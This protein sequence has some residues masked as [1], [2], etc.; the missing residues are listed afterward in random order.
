MSD[1]LSSHG[2][3][4]DR[5]GGP[6]LARIKAWV[7]EQ[8]WVKKL[9]S[10]LGL[11]LLLLCTLPVS[12]LLAHLG[13]GVGVPLFLAL[14]LMPLAVFCIFD[15]VFAVGMMLLVAA[16]VPFALKLTAAPIGTLLDL[17]I[18]L[19]TM[20]ILLRQIRHRDWS[21]LKG[22]LPTMTL[23]WL[24]YNILQVLNPWADSKMA[25]LYTVR[26]V[27][28]QQV[29]FFIAIYAFRHNRR[30]LMILLKSLLLLGFVYAAYGLKQEYLGL[31]SWEETWLY[32][33]PKRFELMFQW[34]RL[35]IA[36]LCGDPTTF[37]ILMAGFSML[38][39]AL[40]LGP[41][42][43]VQKIVLGVLMVL[44]LWSMAYS[45]TRT[46]FMLV[47]IGGI[48]Y[49]GLILNKRVLLIGGFLFLAGTA[50]VLKSTTNPVI[51]RI[52][53]AFNVE[54]DDSMNVRLINQRKIQPYIQR[55]PFGGG[56]GSCG[57]W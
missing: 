35:R 16:L 45:G 38:C 39:L 1:P 10:P 41:T 56:L 36:S 40:L 5:S 23:I 55:H 18:L 32:S 57:V 7:G 46:A 21:F 17:L 27:A 4:F 48:F 28:L 8:L 15:T 50:F 31:S 54:N 37:G 22:P 26:S 51:Y 24:Y 20:G 44:A 34:G 3:L 14:I 12:Y 49:C 53:S 42:R 6:L 9:Y 52:K 19:G 13:I 29:V 11:A 43:E 25:W 30:A 47:P 2:D 33:D